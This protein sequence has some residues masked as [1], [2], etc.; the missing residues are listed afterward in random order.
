MQRAKTI[1]VNKIGKEAADE[2]MKAVESYYSAEK[3]MEKARREFEKSTGFLV[4][5]MAEA[6][7]TILTIAEEH[8]LRSV[9]AGQ[10]T[11]AIKSRKTTKIDAGKLWGL[12]IKKGLAKQYYTIVNPLVGKA[13][14]LFGAKVLKDSGVLT[15]EVN[16]YHSIKVTK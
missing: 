4:K 13:K 16:K 1:L 3:Q 2:V 12:A 15:E 7:E 6:K 8:N 14:A 5:V 9:K 10:L 11:C